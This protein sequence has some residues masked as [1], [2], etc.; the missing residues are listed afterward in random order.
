MILKPFEPYTLTLGLIALKNRLPARHPKYQEIMDDLGKLEA[1]EKGEESVM[2][3][4]VANK[5]PENT[6]IMHNVSW[7]SNFQTQI[8]I[9]ILHPSWCLI[10][11]VKNIKGTLYFKSNPSQLVRLLDDG[12]EEN[13]GSPE[14]Q[15]EQY[16]MGLRY[17]L[18]E[19]KLPNVPIYRAI[20]FAFQNAIIKNP[21]SKMKTLIGREVISY[22]W[23]LPLKDELLDPKKVSKQLLKHLNPRNPFPLCKRYGIETNHLISGVQCP[24]C[25]TFPMNKTLR[26]WYCPKCKINSKLAHQK[27]LNDYNMLISKSI[28][29]NEAMNFL[30]L[31]NRYEAIRILK[32]NSIK[33]IGASRSSRYE[34]RS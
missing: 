21:P 15:V 30:H 29:S 24:I 10:L 2:S 20:V 17:K 31:R 8:D 32:S 7:V 25:G 16:C 4:L 6:V 13:L 27:A 33:Q 26:T 34:L 18:N 5:L 23:S 1:G 9:L 19:L 3:V 14:T 28:S 22:I 12:K 11:E